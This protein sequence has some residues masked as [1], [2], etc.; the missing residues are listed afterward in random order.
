MDCQFPQQLFPSFYNCGPPNLVLKH[1]AGG[2]GC[3]DG[4]IAQGGTGSLSSWTFTSKRRTEGEVWCQTEPVPVPL[5]SPG[6]A[7]QGHLTPPDPL[8][9]LTHMQ[10]FFMDNGPDAFGCMSE[11]LGD[12]FYFRKAKTKEKYRQESVNMWKTKSYVDLLKYKICPMTYRSKSLNKYCS[13][14]SDVIHDVPPELLGSLLYE[15]L[16]EQRDRTQF[17]E[18]ATGGALAFVPFSQS[19]GCLLYP[20]G[21]GMD[22]LNFHKVALQHPSERPPCVDASGSASASFQLKA[23]IRQISC[24][25]LFGDCCVAVRSD[26]LCGVWRFSERKEPSLLQVVSTPAAVTCVSVSPHVLGEVLVAS[27]SGAAH[28]WRVGRGMQKVR[29]EESNLYF[30]AKSSWRWCEFSAH[31]RV[32]LYADKTGAE[33]TD[34]RVK[35][36]PSAGHTLFRISSTADC[37]S[38]ERLLLCRYLGDA[39]AF[40]HL[41]TTQH[42]A[43][44]MDERFPCTPMLKWDHMMQAPPLFCHVAPDPATGGTTKVL[45]GS[46]S[47]QEITLLQYSGGRVEACC[48]RGSPQVLLRPTDSLG[49]LPPQIPHR[50]KPA[51]DRLASP[52]AGLT[53]FQVSAGAVDRLCVL[54]LTEAGD[55]FYQTL[56]RRRPGGEPPGAPEAAVSDPRPPAGTETSPW[57]PA[58]LRPAVCDTSSDEDVVWPTQAPGAQTVV[59]ETPE[60]EESGERGRP[61]R[62]LQVFVN[63]ETGSEASGGGGEEAGRREAPVTTSGRTLHT[64]KVWLQKLR[65]TSRETQAAA[66][67]FTVQTRGLL[68]VYDEDAGAEPQE[69]RRRMRSRSL[70][71]GGAADPVPVP[72]LVD[73]EAWTDPVSARLTV[74]WRGEEEWRAWWQDR[75]GLNRKTKMEALRRKRRREKEA[76]RAAHGHLELTGSFTS[77]V[78]YQT[79]LDDLSG[80]AG[81]SSAVSQG[82]WS[83]EEGGGELAGPAAP[84][85]ENDHASAPPGSQAVPPPAATPKKEPP[86]TRPTTPQTPT[87]NQRRERPGWLYE[88]QGGP[89]RSSGPP[90]RPVASSSQLP[91]SQPASLRP[92][93][94]PLGSSQFLSPS[95]ASQSQRGPS[96]SSQPKK[97]KSRMGF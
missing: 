84:L 10:N 26:H 28:L 31:P 27:E 57:L 72:P 38:G 20:G 51:A 91:G 22:R 85:E 59:P 86:R 37:Q 48:S 79:D 3:Y 8:D 43:Y 41:V 9:F 87:A 13:L 65:Q 46:Q 32:M 77:S 17:S 74:A 63:D 55:V 40:H 66:P 33:L 50:Q 52:A 60:R 4:V 30:N 56:E 6:K 16:M 54:Q 73:G 68:H 15:E 71:L 69:L 11:I 49:R 12:N 23:A 64:W 93:F 2:W 5:L 39:H 21:L 82:A 19:E 90:L 35:A 81:W 1:G 44:V 67:H 75:L 36:A 96:Q 62:R 24:G 29:V 78:S 25:S 95:R 83:D 89:S 47:S 94:S 34:F 53:G 18:G 58:H 7:F 42:S 61:G 88:T 14:L 70:L 45:L 80:S 76:R 92:T 97:K